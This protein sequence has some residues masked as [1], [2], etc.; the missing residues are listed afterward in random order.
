MG[1]VDWKHGDCLNF[2]DKIWKVVGSAERHF[3][4]T[5]DLAWMLLGC[6]LGM[7]PA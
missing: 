1:G 2:S 3:F 4:V 6:G 7:V 5:L